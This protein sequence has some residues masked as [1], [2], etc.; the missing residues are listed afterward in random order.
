SLQIEGRGVIGD[1]V[2]EGK[3]LPIETETFKLKIDEQV[4]GVKTRGRMNGQRVSFNTL[5][6][7]KR[8]LRDWWKRRRAVAVCNHLAGN[9]LATD[10]AYTGL[11]AVSAPD[12]LHIYRQGS[13][14][15]ADNDSTVNGD[16][17]RKFA[18]EQLDLFPTIAEQL[19]VPIKPF[20]ID[21]NPYYGYLA[22]PGMLED[23]R[24]TS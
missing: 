4:Q 13:G 20:I 21:G 9:I 11:N 10:L 12:S 8:K 16:S 3:E 5:E 7:G 6:E 23:M 2:L 1:E 22:T 24:V 17:N 19:P 15:G 18:I 14:L